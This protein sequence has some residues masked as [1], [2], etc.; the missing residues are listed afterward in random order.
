MKIAEIISCL[1]NLANPVLQEQYD[2]AGLLTGDPGWDCTGIIVSL[3]TTEAVVQEAV[4]KK[5][6]CIIA[7]HPIIFSGLKKINSDHY[8][9]KAV[10]A[11]IKNDIAIYAIHTNLDN[12]VTGV[13][14]KMAALLGL[15]NISVLAPKQNLLK[16]LFTFIPV[17]KTEEVRTAIFEA[18]AGNIGNYSECSFNVEGTGTFKPGK[19]TDPYVGK[20]GEQH[21]ENEIKVEVIFPAYLEKQIISTLKAVHPYEEAA[22][23]IVNLSNAWDQTGSG[24]IGELP[25]ALSETN[26]LTR[27]KEVFQTPVI[28]HTRF[29]NQKVS[30]IALCGGA[31]SFLIPKALAVGVQAYITSDIKYHEFFEANDRLLL[32]DIGHFESEQFTISLLQEVLAQ[33]F[34]NFAVLKTGVLTN[35]VLYY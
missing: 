25:E 30:R 8:V 31:G 33:K 28:R 12:V 4:A 34:P 24:I 2:N 7:H 19:G 26:L 18:G 32:A 23:D 21:R 3:D 16:K 10:I 5:C 17:D 11:A 15:K 35:P 27:L 29:I 9:G 14:G 6:N 13:T 20:R 1:E 22:Y